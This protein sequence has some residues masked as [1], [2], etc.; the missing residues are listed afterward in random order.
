MPL[1]KRIQDDTQHIL[2][3]IDASSFVFRAY[4]QSIHQPA[5]YNV[6]SKDDFPTGALRLFAT[7]LYQ[8]ISK[9]TCG[10]KAS[11]IGVVF[12]CGKK[13]FRHTLY[14]EYKAHRPE[15]PDD[16]KRQFSTI[17][18]CVQAFNLIPLE[19]EGYEA[20]DLIASYVEQAQKAKCFTVI[21]SS[22]KDLM[23][24]VNENVCFYDPESGRRGNPG[25][26]A[27]RFLTT[28]EV[29]EKWNGLSP[30]Q[31]RDAL[32]L[33][34]DRSDN[35]PGVPG[36]GPKTA[37]ALLL[38]FH[39]LEQLYAKI[40]E[41]SS[42]KQARLLREH[43]EQAF[44]SLQLATLNC[45]VP[46]PF[47]LQDLRYKGYNHKT[48]TQFLKEMELQTLMTRIHIPHDTEVGL[49][50]LDPKQVEN[51]TSQPLET[52]IDEQRSHM[53]QE[54]W[55]DLPQNP[56]HSTSTHQP[57]TRYNTIFVKHPDQ[58]HDVLERSKL[59]GSLSIDCIELP[60]LNQSVEKC[61]GIA[62]AASEKEIC[63]LICK[64]ENQSLH[65]EP[66]ALF[67][68]SSF[69]EMINPYWDDAT[70]LKLSYSIKHVISFFSREVNL[71]N[72]FDD[73]MV[74]AY[75]CDSGKNAQNLDV[76]TETY[77]HTVSPL[78][79]SISPITENQTL[80]H[81]E[82]NTL[83][84]KSCCMH[85]LH[86]PL[87]HAL[88]KQQSVFLYET[89]ERPL[90]P[91]LLTMERSGVHID[92]EHL[93]QLTKQYK[94]EMES[95]EKE[96]YALAGKTFLISSPKQTGEILH[97]ILKLPVTKKT[98]SGQW[99]TSADDLQALALQ[100]HPFPK[101]ML[102]W[103]LLSK[104]SNTYTIPLCKAL[105]PQTQKIHTNYEQTA[106]ITGRL[107]S[108]Q[109]NLQNIP[110]KTL[111]GQEIRQAFIA[112]KGALLL[113]LDYNQIEL[114]L[115]A[116]FANLVNLK[117]AFE[118]SKD[119]HRVTASLLY[120][121]NEHDVTPEQRRTA[122]TVNFSILYGI[123]S[124]GLSQRLGLSKQDA[125]LMIENYFK[126]FPG[127]EQYIA[128]TKLTCS[129][130]GYVQTLFGR[131]C[132]YPYIYS[133]NHVQKSFAERQ[134]VNAPLQGSSAD[135]IKIAMIAIQ[136]AIKHEQLNAELILQVHDELVFQVEEASICRCA[137]K[138]TSIMEQA[139]APY[140]DLSVPLVVSKKYGRNWSDPQD[141]DQ[142]D[143]NFM[144]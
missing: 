137:S 42:E 46:L 10:L 55:L 74:M 112:K 135:I 108:T 26:R 33:M 30:N 92:R 31:I 101:L 142:F 138:F 130:Q 41:V 144:L 32:A 114:R 54:E 123:S 91:V 68:T 81:K 95:L 25:Y 140:V 23:Q 122:K 58:V 22:D 87:K 6:R 125:K 90:I 88:V 97:D 52:R 118:Q 116:H 84:Y 141:D 127:V 56:A 143:P 107:S 24:L 18:E 133:T 51:R 76:M 63:V 75:C 66:H 71:P 61:F 1:L 48:V 93:E 111:E 117:R 15:V 20:D 53:V 113:S 82:L 129:K 115:L 50:E 47:P 103:R 27:E 8:L 7:K 29:V 102:R 69:V 139:H 13:S 120:E 49:K 86:Q 136:H 94:K 34:G 64:T 72:S 16:L 126:R 131:R 132:Y 12:D 2:F 77:L 59:S 36:I 40:D 100:G 62:L 89:L 83:A 9:P 99:R 73:L 104:L 5:H 35:I 67:S 38:K 4:Y 105:D 98:A 11:H 44:L 128:S 43:K 79:S 121:C 39:S 28:S 19:V 106:T 80:Y 85:M 134:A 37:A 21:L 45:A 65:S 57:I 119:I 60:Q 17:Y 96:I 3:L 70:I 124:Y 109:P 78:H 14:P 110:I